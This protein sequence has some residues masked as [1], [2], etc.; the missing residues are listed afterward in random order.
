MKKNTNG[1]TN[2]NANAIANTNGN[3]NGPDNSPTSTYQSPFLHY[4]YIVVTQLLLNLVCLTL[5]GFS[6]DLCKAITNEDEC[7][8]YFPFALFFIMSLLARH[9]AL[10]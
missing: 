7:H 8:D 5:L 6:P 2:V 10:Y 9:L 3:S 4:Y 1:N